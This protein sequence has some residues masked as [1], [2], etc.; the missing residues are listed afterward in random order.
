[1][2]TNKKVFFLMLLIMG[3]LFTMIPFSRGFSNGSYA[4]NHISYDFDT[5]FGTHDWIALNAINFLRSQSDSYDWLYERLEIVLLGTEAPDNAGVSDILNGETVEGFGDTSSHHNYYKEDGTY[6]YGE[7]DSSIRAKE[8]GGNATY[9]FLEGKLDL[10]AF[11]IG[12]MTHYISDLAVFCHVA[13]NNVDPYPLTDF[14]DNHSQYE[15]YIRSRTNNYENLFEFFSLRSFSYGSK[16]PD[17]T[18]KSLGWDTYRDPNPSEGTVR[19]AKWMH[20]NFFADW[21]QSTASRATESDPIKVMYYDRVEESLNNA[22]QACIYAINRV[23]IDESTS[24][25]GD[26]GPLFTVPS[27]SILIMLISTIAGCFFIYWRKYALKLK[28]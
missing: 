15:S 18:S 19:D 1:M 23:S 5:D 17:E 11:F 24:L 6:I 10:A 26:V 21:A 25:S 8:M 12:A 9:Y 16:S 14:D 20:D 4:D 22:I 7:N 2:R 13:R 3:C 27:F 28:T